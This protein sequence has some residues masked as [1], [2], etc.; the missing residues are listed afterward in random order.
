MNAGRGNAPA[1]RSRVQIRGGGAIRETDILVLPVKLPDS[2]ERCCLVLFEEPKHEPAAVAGSSAG[3][4]GPSSPARWLPPW[5]R[6]LFTRAAASGGTA[7]PAP[8][9]ASDFDRLRQEL[10]AMRDYLQSVIEQKD[11]VNEELRSANE[12]ILSSNEELRSTNEEMET[13]KEE[14]QSVNEELQSV[15]EELVTVNEQ[16]MNRDLELTRVSDDMT[17]L[18]GS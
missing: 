8:P 7:V 11:T 3:A 1:R 16:L 5:S 10:A 14:L 6:R 18:L 13:A 2:H 15:N 4:T 12:E 17:N 9:D